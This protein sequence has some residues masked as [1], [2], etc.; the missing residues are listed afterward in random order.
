MGSSGSEKLPLSFLWM[1]KGRDRNSNMCPFPLLPPTIYIPISELDPLLR[2]NGDTLLW[3]NL[4]AEMQKHSGDLSAPELVL[5]IEIAAYN[6]PLMQ[7][8]SL[9]EA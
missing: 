5:E 6:F 4:K 1:W 8:A 3:I 2:S 7:V 9:D